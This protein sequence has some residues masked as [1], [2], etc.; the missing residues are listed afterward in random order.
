MVAYVRSGHVFPVWALAGDDGVG[1]LLLLA[2]RRRRQRRSVPV[3][4]TTAL[5]RCCR[6]P[7]AANSGVG[8]LVSLAAGGELRLLPGARRRWSYCPV[9]RPGGR[10]WCVLVAAAARPCWSSWA[11]PGISD[12]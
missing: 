12:S 1:P 10:P 5:D 6:W 9:C 7:A 11:M 3:V 4:G 2:G 8:P